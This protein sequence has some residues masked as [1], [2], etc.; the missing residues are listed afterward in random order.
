MTNWSW[1][2]AGRHAYETAFV[3]W[4]RFPK[5]ILLQNKGSF[6]LFWFLSVDRKVESIVH[7]AYVG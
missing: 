2:L 3:P 6:L 1:H 7:G 4:F 5:K